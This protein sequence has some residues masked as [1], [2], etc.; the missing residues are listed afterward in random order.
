M[1]PLSVTASIIVVI[2][3]SGKVVSI[4]YDYR[5]AIENAAEDAIKIIRE[6]KSLQDVLERL[7]QLAERDEAK[8]IP[9]LASL[10]GLTQ[11]EGT[12]TLCRSELSSLKVK[13][14]APQGIKKLLKIMQLPLTEKEVKTTLDSI[15]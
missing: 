13:L 2:Q 9:R 4:C 5:R 15:S 3:I 11:L 6:I 14:E 7:L 1:D 10:Q 12:L 8:K